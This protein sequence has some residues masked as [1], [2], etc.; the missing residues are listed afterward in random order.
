MGVRRKRRPSPVRQVE[1]E[2][3]PESGEQQPVLT[4]QE[5]MLA[6]LVLAGAALGFLYNMGVNTGPAGDFIARL[7]RW[8]FGL[9][10]PLW[11]IYV[12]AQAGV[13]LLGRRRRGGSPPRV[14][15]A[16]L[17]LLVVQVYLHLRLPVNSWHG[18]AVTGLA[19]ADEL[20]PAA[21]A[22][23]GG[24]IGGM[25]TYLLL[26]SFS[27]SG[28]LVVLAAALL[29]A[30]VLTWGPGLGRALLERQP[31][32]RVRQPAAGEAGGWVPKTAGEGEAAA[33]ADPLPA[34][35]QRLEGP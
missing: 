19:L 4:L 20:Q 10:S 9:S 28:T 32:K 7:F 11:F 12:F 5:S 8:L 21:V 31:W 14:V 3:E 29:A 2:H 13:A 25:L 27:Y 23:G 1:Q 22:G 30:A 24:M 26:R 6:V 17:V 33:G 18:T 34:A 35:E 15:A 16:V